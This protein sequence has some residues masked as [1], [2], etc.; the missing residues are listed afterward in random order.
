MDWTTILPWV[1]LAVGGAIGGNIVGAL[2]RG[3]GGIVGRTVIGA[4]GGVALG[5]LAGSIEAVGGITS[6]WSNLIDGDNGVHLSNLITGA[7]GGAILG[8]VGGL[9]MRGGD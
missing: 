8:L 9:L 3:G 4:I 1:V 7:I 6:M 2:L 5:Y